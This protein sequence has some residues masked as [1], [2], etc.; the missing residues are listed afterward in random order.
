M[1]VS[2]YINRISGVDENREVCTDVVELNFAFFLIR[3]THFQEISI[4]VFLQVTWEDPRLLPAD[5]PSMTKQYVE[6]TPSERDTVW[7]PDLYIRQLREMKVMTLLEEFSSLR[8][9]KN[10]TLVL[11]IGLVSFENHSLAYNIV[12]QFF[13]SN[14]NIQ[15]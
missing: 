6:L 10:S 15:V 2:L 5:E 1:A 8:L 13:Q 7:V 9:Y 12:S 4:D 14:N 3:S 11:S